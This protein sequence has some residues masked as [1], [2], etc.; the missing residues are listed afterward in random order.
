MSDSGIDYRFAFAVCAYNN[1]FT[2]R[3][4]PD[5]TLEISRNGKFLANCDVKP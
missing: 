3:V 2:I 1:T 5:G 4:L